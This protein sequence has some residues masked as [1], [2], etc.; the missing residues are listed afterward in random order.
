MT[1][2]DEQPGKTRKPFL[3][4]RW[5]NVALLTY[6]VPPEILAHYVPPNCEL[7][8]R[9]GNAYVSLVAF[10]FHEVKVMGISWPGFRQFP[11]INLRFYV[12]HLGNRGVSFI[13]EF[14]PKRTIAALAKMIYNEPYRSATISSSTQR[15]DQI[16]TVNH[17]LMINGD[18][19][20]LKV[21]GD[22]TPTTAPVDST[23]HFFKEHEWGFGRSKSSQLIRYRVEHPVWEVHAVK[24]FE[25]KWDWE[26]VYGPVWGFLQDQKPESVIL[27][28]GSQVKVFPK[29]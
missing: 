4:A 20:S 29:T 28:A 17:Q 11:E 10:D 25:L 15:D 27:A 18:T 16:I 13:R 6:A 12:R 8:I 19:H 5:S 7:D 21:V 9:L 22:V 23:D 26:K 1:M 14:V 3:T 2:T 24:S